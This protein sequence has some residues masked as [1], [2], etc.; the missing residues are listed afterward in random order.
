ML[1][2]DPPLLEL[3]NGVITGYMIQLNVTETGDVL[4]YTSPTTAVTITTNAFR[5]YTCVVSA[6]T[7]IGF[8]PYGSQITFLTP[9][10][11]QKDY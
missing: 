4:Y 9:E 8:G 6:Q 5:T 1:T 10:D 3:Q 2:W 11:G 7:A